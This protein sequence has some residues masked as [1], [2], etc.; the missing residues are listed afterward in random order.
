MPL[1][2]QAGLSRKASRDFQSKGISI[3]L[4]AELD[5]LLLDR[6]DELQARI[7]GLY[8]QASAAM[9]GQIERMTGGCDPQRPAR[10]APA[11]VDESAQPE[12]RDKAPAREA[13]PDRAHPTHH[14]PAA[15]ENGAASPI[16]P[17]Q[18]RVILGL[19]RLLDLDLERECRQ[20]TGSAFE[21]LSVPQASALLDHL[22]R[23]PP[24]VVHL[25]EASGQA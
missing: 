20:V 22:K 4:A 1:L 25:D 24:P 19:V 13:A 18:R 12:A 15:G 23:F 8:E 16:T 7:A 5:P 21:C 10:R 14:P 17:A 9:Q 3:T 2:I 6:P 11:T